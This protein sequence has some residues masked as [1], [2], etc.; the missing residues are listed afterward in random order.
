AVL[1]PRLGPQRLRKTSDDITSIP[2]HRESLS[3]TVGSA[4]AECSQS[5]QVQTSI[6]ER[7]G[8]NVFTRISQPDVTALHKKA[9]LV[10]AAVEHEQVRFAC[11]QYTIRARHTG[12]ALCADY[13]PLRGDGYS[14]NVLIL[15]GH[16]QPYGGTGQ[17]PLEV[18]G[19]SSAQ[20]PRNEAD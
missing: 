4:D 20:E 3:L 9:P 8:I 5:A 13:N 7:K 17:K 14:I 12:G 10:V 6:G 2:I 19:C 15:I 16:I 18:A 1:H 11:L